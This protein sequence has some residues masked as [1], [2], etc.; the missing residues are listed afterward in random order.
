LGLNY[1]LQFGRPV[2]ATHDLNRQKVKEFMEENQQISQR[3]LVE[4]L[5]TGL[6]SVREIIAGLG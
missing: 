6:A 4:K 2:S 1:Q 5:N 3:E